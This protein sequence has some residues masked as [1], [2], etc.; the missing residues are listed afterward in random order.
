MAEFYSSVLLLFKRDQI[1]GARMAGASV[2]KTAELFSVA[3][4]TVS[5]AM[6]KNHL[7]KKEKPSHRSNTL[8]ESEIC[9]IVGLLRG[10]FGRMIR[11][12]R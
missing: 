6:R 11:I 2:T 3:M 7:R 4:S 8:E 12:Q 10:L 1:L 5:K 9:L